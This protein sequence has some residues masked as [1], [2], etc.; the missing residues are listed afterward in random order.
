MAQVILA[1]CALHKFCKMHEEDM[2]ASD[3]PLG[4]EDFKIEH[5]PHV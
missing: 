3:E 4:L 5:A 1:S 2:G